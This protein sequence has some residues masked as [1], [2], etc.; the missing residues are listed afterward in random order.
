MPDLPTPQDAAEAALFS[1]SWDAVLSYADLCTS[2]SA[3]GRQLAT[4][5]FSRGAR[6]AHATEARARG[7]GRRTPR[8]PGIPLLLTAVRATAAAWEA[9]GEGHLL[10]PDLRLWLNS[11]KAARYTGPPLRRPLALRGL[12][13]MQEADAAL[14]WLAEAEA[15]PLTDVARRLGL[16]PAAASVELAQVR[17]LFRDRCLRNRLDTPM[18]ADCRRYARLLDAV[19]RS[20]AGE[21]PEDLS[22]HLATCVECAEAAACLRLHGGGTPAAL[23]SGVI[24]WGGLAY[25]ER[26]RRAAEAGLSGGRADAGTDRGVAVGTETRPRIGRAGILA[27]AVIVSALALTVS[28][29]QL[30][31]SDEQTTAGG[32]AAGSQRAADPVPPVPSFG[33]VTG[34]GAV[35]AFPTAR[36][37]PSAT[38][39]KSSDSDT[40]PQGKSTSPM[41]ASPTASVPVKATPAPCQVNYHVDSEWSDGFQATVTVTST[42]ALDDWNIGWTFEDGQRITQMWDGTFAQGGSEVTA[43]ATAY[44]R[45]VAANGRVVVGFVSSWHGSNSQPRDFTVNGVRCSTAG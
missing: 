19:T 21:T 28:L 41:D 7:A 17:A 27:A 3:A 33:S 22:R 15:L 32:D 4:E 31:N 18:D 43:M 23:A 1:E 26:R 34:D 38:V 36:P 12:R 14:L 29:M 5:A 16:D 10:D 8:L 30:G 42:R 24:G 2:G 25:L 9:E 40:E 35:G 20:S 13:D 11:E 37:S 45:K 6:E 44:N 39:A